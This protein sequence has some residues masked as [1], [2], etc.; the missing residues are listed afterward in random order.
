VADMFPVEDDSG[1]LV[2]LISSRELLQILANDKLKNKAQIAVR[3]VMKT[4]IATI[5]PETDSLEAL[6]IMREK[7]IGC[8]PVV[9]NNKLIGI[10]TAHDFL[11][12]SAK[13][14]E[15]RLKE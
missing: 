7:G 1:N 13:L 15:E 9:K 14:F 12:V 5:S 3:D 6:K 11:I 2:G 8:L 4:D 10:I